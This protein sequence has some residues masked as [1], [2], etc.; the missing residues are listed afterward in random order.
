MPV[1]SVGGS[2]LAR[3]GFW[4]PFTMRF[5][6]VGEGAARERAFSRLGGCHGVAR[7]RI[8]IDSVSEVLT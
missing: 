8:R 7:T 1:W 4:Q 6:A 2:F 5:E 3:R